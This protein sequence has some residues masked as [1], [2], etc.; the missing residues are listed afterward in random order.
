[1]LEAISPEGTFTPA[2]LKTI[3]DQAIEV[4]Q[5]AAVQAGA[6]ADVT[7][8]PLTPQDWYQSGNTETAVFSNQVALSV[9]STLYSEVES[10][11]PT[12]TAYVL[13]GIG[14]TYPTPQI[15]EIWIGTKAVTWARIRL[16]PLYV[17]G[18]GGSQTGVRRGYF[19]PIY[20]VSTVTPRLQYVSSG[21]VAQYGETYELIGLVA[22]PSNNVVDQQ[23]INKLQ[24]ATQAPAQ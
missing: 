19:N 5:M 22:D 17:Y 16:T 11:V 23:P 7:I 20:F 1:M 21:A 9:A 4:T 2:Q 13:Y 10:A 18:T 24:S 8:R 15:Q 3:K 6:A 14:I 12:A